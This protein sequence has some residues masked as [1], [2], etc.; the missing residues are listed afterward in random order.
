MPSGVRSPPTLSPPSA[1]DR[2]DHAGLERVAEGVVGRD[3]IEFLAVV[4]DQRGGDGVRLH[5]RRVAD[6][7]HVPVAARAG[8]R[9]GMAAGNDVQDALFV[10]HLRHGERERRVHVAEQEIDLV[11]LDQLARLLH[12]RAG[13]AA[14][15]ILDDELDRTAENAALGVDLLER[16]LAAD[17]FVLAERGVGAGQRIVEADPDRVR[18]AR[19]ND[20]GARDLHCGEGQPRFDEPAA[21]D[22]GGRTELG[23]ASSPLFTKLRSSQTRARLFQR[24]CG[25]LIKQHICPHAAGSQAQRAVNGAGSLN[26]PCRGLLETMRRALLT[27][28]HKRWGRQGS[29]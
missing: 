12:R 19:A 22:A 6:A 3:V 10:R 18:G 26:Q 2:L 7:E 1:A 24:S 28:A 16:H 4:L 13:V 5:L 9:V 11:A 25:F 20:E 14:G 8:D 29:L 15:R 17:Q 27:I 23:H 21:A